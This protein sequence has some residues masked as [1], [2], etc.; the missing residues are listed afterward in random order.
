MKLPVDSTI[1]DHEFVF[2]EDETTRA[3][4]PTKEIIA[5]NLAE[6][7]DAEFVCFQ[8]SFYKVYQKLLA[9]ESGHFIFTEENVPYVRMQTVD[10]TGYRL[11]GDSNEDL[12]GVQVNSPYLLK[13]KYD[14]NGKTEADFDERTIKCSNID[15]KV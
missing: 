7:P 8:V 14:F 6:S 5:E 9:I 15:A 2:T 1:E 4:V 11:L 12:D 13:F 10:S 3:H